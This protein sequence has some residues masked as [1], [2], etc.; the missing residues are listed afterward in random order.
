MS[1]PSALDNYFEHERPIPIEECF[2]L[3]MLYVYLSSP[4]S[5]NS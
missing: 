1:P 2:T 5:V 4:N 3:L